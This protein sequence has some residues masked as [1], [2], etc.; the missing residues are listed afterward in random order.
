VGDGG[1]ELARPS[2][3]LGIGSPSSRSIVRMCTD[4]LVATAE[5]LRFQEK[6]CV[7]DSELIPSSIIYPI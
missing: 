4:A 3:L 7:F 5:G 2:V 1:P 6:I